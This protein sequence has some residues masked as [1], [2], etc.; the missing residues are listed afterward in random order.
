M[1]GARA[2]D[3]RLLFPTGR[4]ASMRPID[5]KDTGA[6]LEWASSCPDETVRMFWQKLC[7]AVNEPETASASR[8][9][10]EL[11]AYGGNTI[12]N[13]FRG[14]GV[15]YAEVAFD[16][17]STLNGMFSADPFREGDVEACERFV[18][19]KMEVKD[20]DL[21][22]MCAGID[23]GGVGPAVRAQAGFAAS[24]A[25]AEAAAYQAARFAAQEAAKRAAA[26]AAKAAGKKAAAQA[27]KAAARKA[28][29]AAAQQVAKQVLARV[30]A[31]LNVALLALT[32]IDLAGP[33]KRVT[34][35]A[36][37]YV[38]LLR[39][40]YEGIALGFDGREERSDA[41]P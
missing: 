27:A 21:R 23:D 31:A 10:A 3:R 17:A 6:V 35:P 2:S 5:P 16:V 4:R 8:V 26:E 19:K 7:E 22:A 37:T 34:I 30:L 41:A 1:G 14:E 32:V 29:Q 38:A 13:M 36:V 28:A 33:A 15:P 18:L 25:A 20:D 12:A 11:R 24:V 9:Y 39:K 40:I